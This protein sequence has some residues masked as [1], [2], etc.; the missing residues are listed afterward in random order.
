MKSS[1]TLTHYLAWLQKDYKD[2][3]NI[4]EM[5]VL[6]KPQKRYYCAIHLHWIDP[7][8]VFEDIGE[9][10]SLNNLDSYLMELL[11]FYERYR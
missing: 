4:R 5:G 7:K 8:Y 9:M 11:R 10:R 2:T 3:H 1:K 6:I